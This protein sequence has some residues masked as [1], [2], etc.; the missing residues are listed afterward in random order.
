MQLVLDRISELYERFQ[1]LTAPNMK[2]T[3]FRI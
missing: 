2:I 3:A 1:V